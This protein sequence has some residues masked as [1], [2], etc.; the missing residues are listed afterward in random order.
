MSE[1]NYKLISEIDILSDISDS[2]TQLIER[3]GNFKR[4]PATLIKDVVADASSAP[5]IISTATGKMISVADSGQRSLSNLRLFGRTTH[6]GIPADLNHA[7]S[8]GTV[9]VKAQGKNLLNAAEWGNVNSYGLTVSINQDGSVNVN[10]TNTMDAVTTFGPIRMKLPKGTYFVSGGT[11]SSGCYLVVDNVHDEASNFHVSPSSFSIESD[12][13]TQLVYLQIAA[14]ATVNE[15]IYPQIEQGSSQTEFAPFSYG[16]AVA[17]TTL[18]GVP[19]IPVSVNGNYTDENGQQWICDE[20]D[21][22]RGVY[23]QRIARYVLNESTPPDSHN[24]IYRQMRFEWT[25]TDYSIVPLDYANVGLQMCNRFIPNT[26]SLQLNDV[27][28]A[29]STYV[30]GGIYLRYD[31]AATIEEMTAYLAEHPIEY[32][33]VMKTPIEVPL[34]SDNLTEFK[35]MT[36][37][38]PHTTVYNDSDMMMAVDYVADTKNY[39]DQKIATIAA[40]MLK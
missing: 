24:E 10:G 7:G 29:I 6:A 19:G 37:R 12:A 33:Y 1:V 25:A 27:D 34:F 40:A 9:I 16:G 21:F 11:V 36:S 17:V 20:V 14:S 18:D 15:T 8:N 5:P 3:D 30:G 38:Y 22:G 26:A 4:L 32:L 35:S 31:G 28:G 2:D 39:I 23:V 13:D